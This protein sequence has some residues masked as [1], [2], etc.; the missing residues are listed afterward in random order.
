MNMTI[1]KAGLRHFSNLNRKI[2]RA[3]LCK[4][5]L[6]DNKEH[7]TK[8][9][10]SQTK[11]ACKLPLKLYMPCTLNKAIYSVMGTGPHS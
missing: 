7:K 9:T 6:I 3:F 1:V 2:T 8:T 11:I 10:C 4:R 5:G